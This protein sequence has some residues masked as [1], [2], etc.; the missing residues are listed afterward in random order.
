M[1][2]IY[3]CGRINSINTDA[4]CNHAY[5]FE[6]FIYRRS[7]GLRGAKNH[8]V[9]I[10]NISIPIPAKVKFS[11]SIDLFLLWSSGLSWKIKN[12]DTN[13]YLV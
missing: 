8:E 6:R 9:S 10:V 5:R 7:T 2:V 11:L 4:H 12:I 3:R 13:L 1:R